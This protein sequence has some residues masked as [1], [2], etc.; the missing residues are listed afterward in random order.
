M[1]R[2][3]LDTNIIVSGTISSSGSPYEVLEAW[4]HRKFTLITS[5]LILEE[6]ERVFEYPK[7]MKSY[8]L[9]TKTIRAIMVRLKRYSVATK[10][11]VKVD[12]IKD[13]PTDNVFLA[14]A[15]EGAAGFVVSGDKHLLK[16]GFFEGIPI[17]SPRHFLQ[18]LEER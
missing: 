18:I 5:P 14:C 3:V 6:T 17:V 9:D 7:I 4:R 16:L 1:I 15:K 10:G 11:K 8:N 12:E 2:A 13:D